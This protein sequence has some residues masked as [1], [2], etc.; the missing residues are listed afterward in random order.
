MCYVHTID[1]HEPYK[2]MK[3][4]HLQHM[5]D[6]GGHCVRWNIGHRR[7]N[8]ADSHFY[9][10]VKIFSLTEIGVNSACRRPWG[11]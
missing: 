8:T 4:F 5:A 7:A 1:Y 3:L 11:G 9:V 6:P 2:L 10:K